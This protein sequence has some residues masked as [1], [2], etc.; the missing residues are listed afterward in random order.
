[1][2]FKDFN[3]FPRWKLIDFDASC[4]YHSLL[5]SSVGEPVQRGTIDFCSPETLICREAAVSM[6]VFSLGRVVQWMLSKSGD[7]WRAYIKDQNGLDDKAKY[8]IL[9]SDEPLIVSLQDIDHQATYH[10]IV[11]TLTKDPSARCTLCDIK[12]TLIINCR[13][14]HIFQEICPP[15]RWKITKRMNLLKRTKNQKWIYLM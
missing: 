12:V 6:D 4:M 13:I 1:M 7:V 15:K 2:M 14:L 8:D 9:L 11:K 10:F 5:I 3:D